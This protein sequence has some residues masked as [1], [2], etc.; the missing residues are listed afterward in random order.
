M[1]CGVGCRRGSDPKLLWLWPWPAATALIGPLAWESP[2]AAGAA[3]KDKKIKINKVVIKY[4]LS[5]LWAG[6]LTANI[7]LP[8]QS[9]G[10]RS[11]D[12]G[13]SHCSVGNPGPRYAEFPGS[14]SAGSRRKECLVCGQAH[15]KF[16]PSSVDRL[17]QT[18]G[19][20]PKSEQGNSTKKEEWK[21]VINFQS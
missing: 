2:Y 11:P 7:I 3:P 9:R 12:L 4:W 14:L 16:T 10:S 6:V 1:S 21:R 13:C 5:S 20:P 17:L 15:L 18:G 8:S 19:L